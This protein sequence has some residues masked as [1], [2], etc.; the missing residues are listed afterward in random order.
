VTVFFEAQRLTTKQFLSRIVLRDTTI[1]G[2]SFEKGNLVLILI[3][4]C[5]QNFIFN[6]NR[7]IQ[8]EACRD[9]KSTYL[10]G[11][12]K[13]QLGRPKEAYLQYGWGPHQCLGREVGIMYLVEMI[14][15]AATPKQLR[16]APGEMGVLKAIIV[17]NQ[18]HYLSEN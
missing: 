15:L 10:P 13:F 14:K 1:E 3:V 18:L 9:A 6:T 4:S 7:R 11:T 8:G 2:T 17:N 16:P 5:W 12:L